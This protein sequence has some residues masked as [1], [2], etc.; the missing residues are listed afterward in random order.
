[1]SFLN[2]E[3]VIE[4]HINV[5]HISLQELAKSNNLYRE[6]NFHTGQLYAYEECLEILQLC[7]PFRTAYLNYEIEKRYPLK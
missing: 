3:Q 6:N 2:E 4:H 1:M 5:I 7:S